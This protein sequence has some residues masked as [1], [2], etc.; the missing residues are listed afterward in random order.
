MH[1]E[2]RE[3]CTIQ[4]SVVSRYSAVLQCCLQRVK[5]TVGRQQN[6]PQICVDRQLE[7][8]RKTKRGGLREETRLALRGKGILA[9][10]EEEEK[11]KVEKTTSKKRLLFLDVCTLTYDGC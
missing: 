1:V 2:R 7:P 5:D 8:K 9:A 4:V 11:G 10:A 6:H 3:G